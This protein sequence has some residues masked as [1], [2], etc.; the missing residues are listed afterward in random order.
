MIGKGIVLTAAHCVSKF[1]D[2][3]TGFADKVYFIPAATKTANAG[4]SGP[5][6]RWLAKDIVVPT[7]YINGTCK[8]TSSSG[9]VTSNDLAIVI[10]GGKKSKLPYR[11]G[12]GY[13]G[14][15]WNGYG[16]TKGSEFASSKSMGEITQLGYPAAI[17]DKSTNRG[18]A[19]IRTDSMAMYSVPA[20]GVKNLIWGSS[21]TGGASGGPQLVNFGNKP[22]YGS[23]A[24]AG[25]NSLQNILVG[26][27]SWG[28]TDKALKVMGSSWFGTNTEFA[29]GSYKDDSGKDWGAGNIGAIMRFVCG[30][31]KGYL[32]YQAKGWC[33]N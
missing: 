26:T 25:T 32:D 9:V 33:R 2:G 5:I 1:G 11:K 6:G 20:S 4:S 15:G 14:Y 30:S 8:A 22:N 13:Y 28:Y 12:A 31:G 16:F 29:S 24:S 18:G 27:T 17:G 10:L 3:A 7:C 21:Q 19:M 23:S